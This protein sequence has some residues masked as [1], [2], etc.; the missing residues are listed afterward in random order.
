MTRPLPGA[1]PEFAKGG[2]K[3]EPANVRGPARRWPAS[4]TRSRT[5]AHRGLKHSASAAASL[6]PEHPM[7]DNPHTEHTSHQGGRARNKKEAGQ[8][9]PPPTPHKQTSLARTPR[10]RG[11]LAARPQTKQA[12]NT[13][14]VCRCS[15]CTCEPGDPPA[16]IAT[17]LS[18]PASGSARNGKLTG[19]CGKQC[20]QTV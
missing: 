14:T 10:A 2:G 11:A 9:R 19:G 3:R 13:E 1:P 17:C 8:S 7:R 20:R 6:T 4:N 16:R 12:R 5:R 18:P 15:V